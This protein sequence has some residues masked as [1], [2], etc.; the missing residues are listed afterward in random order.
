MD[1]SHSRSTITNSLSATQATPAQLAVPKRHRNLAI[2]PAKS[3]SPCI[4]ARIITSGFSTLLGMRPER[5]LLTTLSTWVI[6]STSMLR[7]LMVGVGLLEESPSRMPSVVPFMITAR[8]MRRTAQ[9]WIQ[10][11]TFSPLRGSRF[12]MTMKLVTIPIV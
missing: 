9:I 2:R 8:D 1:W 5:T 12:G 7:G 3:R 11:R 6:S 4:P 10:L